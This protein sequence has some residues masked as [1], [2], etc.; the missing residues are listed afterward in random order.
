MNPGTVS[1]TLAGD[2]QDILKLIL[3]LEGVTQGESPAGA[4]R[5]AGLGGVTLGE[6]SR[7]GNQVAMLVELR[8]VA[9]II[10]S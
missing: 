8:E 3:F 7:R 4:L 6:S 1:V 9:A 2:P 10:T 5:L